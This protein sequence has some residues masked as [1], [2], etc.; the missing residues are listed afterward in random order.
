MS[1]IRMKKLGMDICLNIRCLEL[2][3]KNIN[4]NYVS[5]VLPIA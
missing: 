2:A 1:Y 5:F 4:F 3:L